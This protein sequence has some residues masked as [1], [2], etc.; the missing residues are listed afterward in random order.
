M[1]NALAEVAAERGAEVL[2]VTA[3]DPSNAHGIEVVRV[4]T[5]DEMALNVWGRASECDVVVM[6]AAVADFKP[7]TTEADKIRRADGVPTIDLE[8][9]PDVLKGVHEMSPRPFLV[10]FAAETGSL[11]A[12]VA[13]AAAKGVDLLVANDVTMP[14]AGFGSDMNEVRLVFRDGSTQDLELLPKKE[15]ASAIWDTV[16][17]LREES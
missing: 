10:G 11:D 12:A 4:D 6:A 7:R 8:P 17:R 9:A 3:A 15:V 5:A 2:L 13:K 16:L 14:G 1:G